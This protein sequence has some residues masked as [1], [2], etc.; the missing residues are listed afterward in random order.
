MVVEPRIKRIYREIQRKLFYMIPEKWNKVYLY[1]S[2]TK[3]PNNLETGE[4]YF[5]YIP[6]GVLKKNPVNVYEIPTKFSI[7]DK[8]YLSLVD[9]LYSDI[10]RLQRVCKELGEEEWNSIVISIGDF[11]FNVEY[12]YENQNDIKYSSYE[13]HLIFRYKYLNYPISSFSKNE[14]EIIQRYLYDMQYDKTRKKIYSEPM[15]EMPFRTIEVGNKN[16]NIQYVKE[17]DLRALQEKE[18]RKEI[19]SQILKSQ[20]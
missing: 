4:L 10:K 6:K 14:K 5:Y 17:E 8:E 15:Y 20:F 16:S 9:N 13:K 12:N 3:R 2:I 18:E 7:D 19:K 1:S 11:K